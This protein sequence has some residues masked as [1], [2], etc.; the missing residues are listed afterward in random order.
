MKKHVITLTS[1]L[2]IST[3]LIC[4]LGAYLKYDILKP[5]GLYQDASIVEVPFLLM[6]DDA[7]I[8]ALQ[9]QA[10]K[11]NQPPETIPPATESPVQTEP[12]EEEPTEVPTE[13]PTEPIVITENWFDDVLFIGDSRTVGLRDM[14]RLGEADY[15]CAGSMSVFTVQGWECSDRDFFNKYLHQVLSTNTYGKIYIH[16][17]LNECGNDHDLVIEKY[18]DLIDLV[19]EK[20]K[21]AE[22]ILQSVMTVTKYKADNPNF[23]LEKITALNERIKTLAE[24]NELHF[25][26]TNELMAD[27][28][29]YLR[30]DYAYDG[31]HPTGLGYQAWA[32][33]IFDTAS[34]L[35]I[36]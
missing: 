17:G 31:A 2:L 36:P 1:L 11:E 12:E 34:E 32:Q 18:Q 21:D 4:S 33:W 16:L 6:A 28:E 24:E 14:A 29:G 7:A 25:I 20:Q 27:E 26:D 8:Y 23:S 3:L 10:V 30:E 22:L 9:S 35:G 13:P 5:L 19:Q 15:F